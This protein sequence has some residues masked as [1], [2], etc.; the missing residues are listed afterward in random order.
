MHYHFMRRAIPVGD[1]DEVR[2][3]AAKV[4]DHVN[5]NYDITLSWGMTLFGDGAVVWTVDYPSLAVYEQTLMKLQGD[6]A[7]WK[8][9]ADARGLFLE[10]SVEDTLVAIM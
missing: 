7:Y 6:Q 3:F 9:I 2:E 1:M 10:G 5:D 4:T 8:M